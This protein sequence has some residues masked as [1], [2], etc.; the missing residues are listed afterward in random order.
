MPRAAHAELPRPMLSLG[1][2][3]ELQRDDRRGGVFNHDAV[4]LRSAGLPSPFSDLAVARLTVDDRALVDRVAQDRPKGSLRP[5]RAARCGNTPSGQRDGY[6]SQTLFVDVGLIDLF[7]D[8]SLEWIDGEHDCFALRLPTAYG[9]NSEGTIS[10]ANGAPQPVRGLP[11]DPVAS[12]R[13]SPESSGDN[14]A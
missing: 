14:L 5:R 4:G 9:K 6:G 11:A 8:S 7:D 10:L 12:L 3:P 13:M 1:R 2:L